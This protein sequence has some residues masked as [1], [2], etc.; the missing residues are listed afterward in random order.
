MK[1]SREAGD[2]A[3]A[4]MLHADDDSIVSLASLGG[5]TI[6]LYFYPRDDTPGCTTEACEFRDTWARVKAAG[7]IVIGIS[8]D[9]VASHGRFKRKLSLP[10]PLLADPDH[11][12]AEAYGVWG[13]KSMFGKKYLGVLRTTFIID[14]GGIIRH[15]FRQ[16]RAKG[17]AEEILATL[18]GHRAS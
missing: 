10:F 15:V 17:H 3:P 1:R 12:V 11:R 7:A 2:P 4:F 16:V 6:V 5:R 18:R 9:S 8:P 14:S 13:E